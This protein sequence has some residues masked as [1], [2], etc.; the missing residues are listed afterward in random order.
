[1]QDSVFA[2][3]AIGRRCIESLKLVCVARHLVAASGP[4]VSWNVPDCLSD[5][6]R[7][8]DVP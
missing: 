1:M 6:G 7:R 4:L 3:G 5:P 8:W 2:A